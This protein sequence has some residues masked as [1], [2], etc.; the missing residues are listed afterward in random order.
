MKI[1]QTSALTSGLIAAALVS[2]LATG[3]AVAGTTAGAMKG[4]AE[5]GKEKA[6]QICQAC[7]G[8]DGNG[9]PGQPVWPKLAGQHPEYIQ[10]QL[11]NFKNNERWNAQMSPMAMPLTEE[12]IVNLAAYYS[13]LEQSGGTAEPELVELG[14]KIYRAGN[15]VTGVPACSGCHGPA[16]LGSNLAKFPRISGQFSEYTEQTLKLFREHERANDPNAMMRG[17]A[18]RM[19]DTEMAAVAAYI[20]GLRQ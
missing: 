5:K 4:D 11:W 8:L 7:H 1:F 10:K 6:G 20:E 9:I 18:A 15:P 17:V 16:G 2:T 3:P 19:T 14:E 12:E 13:S